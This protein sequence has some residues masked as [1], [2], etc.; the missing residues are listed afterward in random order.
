MA[1]GVIYMGD[2]VEAPPDIVGD[3]RP[4]TYIENGMV[5]YRASAVGNCI[6]SLYYSRTGVEPA[7]HP[8]WLL[9]AFRKGVENEPVIL[10]M[11]YSTTDWRRDETPRL[12]A[13]SEVMLPVGKSVMIRGHIDDVGKRALVLA[14]DG[15]H[16][17]DTRVV[18]AKALSES[19]WQK[20]KKHGIVSVP[21]YAMQLS[22]YMAATGLPGLFV[23][24]HKD[25]DGVVQRVTPLLVDEFPVP[26]SKIKMKVMQVEKCVRNGEPPG[27]DYIQYP[28]QFYYLHDGEELTDRKPVVEVEDDLLDSL[29]AEYEKWQ[30]VEKDAKKRKKA[31]G[32]GLK[33]WFDA[34]ERKGQVVKTGRYEVEDLV[35][36]MPESVRKGYEMRYPK[37]SKVEGAEE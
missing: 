27:C 10:D 9:K 4:N 26:L 5:I 11:L 19:Y 33:G 21:F 25:E 30:L 32:D 15:T 31:A 3:N 13:Q 6:Q 29:A 14:G 37:V 28:C 7:P 8:D 20:I 1:L 24:G 22:V 23:V 16:I 35:V 18:E 34:E 17:F 12:G 36:W 2:E